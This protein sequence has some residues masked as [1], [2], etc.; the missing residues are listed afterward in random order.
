MTNERDPAIALWLE[1]MYG[2]CN[3][4]ERLKRDPLAIVLG[5]KDIRD[6]E[7]A[8]LVCS[9]LAFGKVDL[10]MD[11]CSRALTPL[12][13]HPASALKSMSDRDIEAAWTGF[14]Y[15]FCF[16]RDMIALMKALRAAIE[17]YGSLQAM[18]V[19][20]DSRE[21]SVAAALGGF[22]RELRG[23]PAPAQG[24]PAI[25][26]NLLPD[27]ADGSACKRLL[28]YL[29]WM[30]RKDD[31]DP[32]G[33]DEV[34]PARL[35]VPLDVHMARLCREKLRFLPLRRGPASP[36]L[37][38]ALEATRRFAVYAPEDPVKYDFALTRLGIDPFPGDEILACP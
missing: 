11:A 21:P 37:K 29:R 12:G 4:L 24:R 7:I 22:V 33:W 13:P 8:G 26:P 10:I 20:H 2:E 5:F 25:R 36:T 1:R 27:P 35:I 15:R 14:Q 16:P 9:T 30:V 23:V 38:E 6:R 19:S 17:R 3:R 18:F 32:G 31:I 34:S 28:L